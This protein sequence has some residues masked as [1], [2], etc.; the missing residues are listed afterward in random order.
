[1]CRWLNGKRWKR[2]ERTRSRRIAGAD[3]SD[4]TVSNFSRVRENKGRA[5]I[6]AVIGLRRVN[7]VSCIVRYFTP[8]AGA[9]RGERGDQREC[10]LTRTWKRSREFEVNSHWAVPKSS[11]RSSKRRCS[12]SR[13]SRESVYETPLFLRCSVASTFE[14]RNGERCAGRD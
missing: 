10:G 13:N 5:K 3:A 2:K 9:R 12:C 7:S 14:V 1:M 4:S 6:K 11:G 8:S